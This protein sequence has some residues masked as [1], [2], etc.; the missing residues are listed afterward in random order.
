[1]SGRGLLHQFTLEVVVTDRVTGTIYHIGQVE[2]CSIFWG[3]E[4]M[5]LMD[6]NFVSTIN[7]CVL[8]A[9]LK[10]STS[11][12]KRRRVMDVFGSRECKIATSAGIF[13]RHVLC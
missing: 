4:A 13:R 9:F 1:M 3:K 10:V 7:L 11:E 8:V 2:D 12:I 5:C 6:R